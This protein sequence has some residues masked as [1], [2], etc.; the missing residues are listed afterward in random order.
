MKPA[1]CPYI[2]EK[3]GTHSQCAKCTPQKKWIYFLKSK[4]ETGYYRFLADEAFRKNS[5]Y[6]EIW[7]NDGLI[8]DAER[9][10]LRQHNGELWWKYA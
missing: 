7:Y 3:C 1:N 8:T 2:D 10:E 9:A 5:C 6:I 4:I